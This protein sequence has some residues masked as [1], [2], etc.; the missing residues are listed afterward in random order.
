MSAVSK[1]V[2]KAVCHHCPNRRWEHDL[3]RCP[4]QHCRKPV[5]GLCLAVVDN[6]CAD[7]RHERKSTY[8]ICQLN[9]ID[10][11]CAFCASC[12]QAIC[13]DHAWVAVC[14]HDDAVKNR[15]FWNAVCTRCRHNEMSGCRICTDEAYLRKDAL[16]VACH[17]RP[18]DQLQRCATQAHVGRIAYYRAF[19]RV[20][21]PASPP[22]SSAAKRHK[23][24]AGAREVEAVMNAA[25]PL[26]SVMA[27]PSDEDG[28]D[29]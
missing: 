27:R 29:K 24:S 23:T 18:E 1:P 10:K 21:R 28:S 20:A 7:C 22:P 17:C 19:H 25:L 9:R 26:E 3:Q 6:Y 13:R 5:C 4:I 12:F 11:P 14:P 15:N 8:C 2:R 16:N